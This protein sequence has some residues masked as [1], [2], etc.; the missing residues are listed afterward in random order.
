MLALR[1]SARRSLAAA[2]LLGLAPSTGALLGSVTV[3]ALLGLLSLCG[4]DRDTTTGAML[5]V[6]LGFGV[7]FL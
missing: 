6:G 2:V 5:A 4:P 7:L 3:G 1:R